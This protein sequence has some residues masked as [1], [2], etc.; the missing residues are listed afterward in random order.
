MF[1]LVLLPVCIWNILQLHFPPSRW[2]RSNSICFLLQ[3]WNSI[4]YFYIFDFVTD[5]AI[6]KCLLGVWAPS[7]FHRGVKQYFIIFNECEP[8]FTLPFR[9]LHF[10]IVLNQSSPS[11]V[12]SEPETTETQFW[13][14]VTVYHRSSRL[15]TYSYLI[16]RSSMR[17]ACQHYHRDERESNYL[18]SIAR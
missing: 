10:S 8:C 13:I 11:S 3:K 12:S 15:S 2:K 14:H 16:F 7:E 4:Y 18:Y 17:A 9:K 6:T 5:F 1:F